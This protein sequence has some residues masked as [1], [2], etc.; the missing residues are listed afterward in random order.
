LAACATPSDLDLSLQHPSKQGKFVVRMEPPAAGPTINQLH[1]WQV[2]VNAPDG[3]PVSQAAIAFDGG[4]PQ[5]G[6]GFPTKPRVTR[7][8]SPG[9]YALEG[10]KFSMTGWWD[11][12]LA[13]QAG[14]ASDTA[15][16]NVIVTDDGIKR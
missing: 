8:L 16:F 5:H 9:I 4:M 13:I 7:E 14:D 10:M 11:M 6:H 2:K 12:R 1:A 3:T 15:A